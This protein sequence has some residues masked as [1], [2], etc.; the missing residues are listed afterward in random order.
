M[1]K[2]F[3]IKE[4]KE[5]FIWRSGQFINWF[6]CPVGTKETFIWR[7]GQFINWFVCPVGTVPNPTRWIMI[8]NDQPAKNPKNC[9]EISFL[10]ETE[11]KLTNT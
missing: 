9:L 1:I 10:Q 8:K 4:L 6:V 7:S 11:K 2:T 3:I 5:T